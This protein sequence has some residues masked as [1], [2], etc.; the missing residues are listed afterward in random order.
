MSSLLR[1]EKT[2]VDDAKNDVD[3]TL[4]TRMVVII[5]VISIMASISINY[6]NKVRNLK[7]IRLYDFHL[8]ISAIFSKKK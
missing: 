1:D 7:F 4:K 8:G 3:N 5:I 2:A 6:F